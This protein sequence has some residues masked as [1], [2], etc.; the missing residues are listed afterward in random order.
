[1][2]T[3]DLALLCEAAE[4]D[5]WEAMFLAAPSDFTRQYGVAVQRFESVVALRSTGIGFMLLNRVMGVGIQQPATEALLDEIMA[6]YH[7]AGVKQFAIQLCPSALPED[8][9]LWLEARGF[10][11]GDNWAKCYRPPTPPAP[12]PT[13]LRI[14]AVHLDQKEQL[15]QVVAAGFGMPLFIG[16]FVTAN[17]DQPD[18]RFYV[19]YD[20]DKPVATGALHVKNDVG[21]LGAGA[22]LPNF[23]GRGGQG[24]IMTR[25][26]QDGI[27]AGCEWLTTETGEDSPQQPNPSYHNMIRTGFKLA[28]L[29]TNYLS[30]AQ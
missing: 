17:V 7:L 4:A 12:V 8:L 21:W 2:S 6:Y 24:A 18:W 13:A 15:A 23:R 25:R 14:E 26:I 22:T 11:R 10:T 5:A 29:R 1:M 16:Q 28:Y 30:P 20:G 27:A 9:P 19:G 3:H